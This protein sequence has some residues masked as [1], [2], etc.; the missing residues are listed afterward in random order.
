MRLY[1]PN[2]T[3]VPRSLSMV[4]WS[5]RPEETA[6]CTEA[7]L[8]GEFTLVR[9][10]TTPSAETRPMVTTSRKPELLGLDRGDRPRLAFNA[11][12]VAFYNLTLL[13]RDPIAPRTCNAFLTSPKIWELYLQQDQ[14]VAIVQVM[15]DPDHNGAD[16][17]LHCQYVGPARLDGMIL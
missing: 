4:Y 17:K 8:C 7:G 1:I 14:G 6:T 3:W 11:N 15:S 2:F 10:P 9:F 5:G 16:S 13:R 12:G